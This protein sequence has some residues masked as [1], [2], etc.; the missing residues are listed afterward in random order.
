MRLTNRYASIDF[1]V[2][3]LMSLIPPLMAAMVDQ[4]MFNG[5]AII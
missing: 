1:Y 5:F 4:I 3:W 2:K